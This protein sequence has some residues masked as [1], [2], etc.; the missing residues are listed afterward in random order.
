MEHKVAALLEERR[1]LHG[2]VRGILHHVSTKGRTNRP[3]GV[4]SAL[5]RLNEVT[6]RVGFVLLAYGT[7]RIGHPASR[8]EHHERPDRGR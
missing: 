1:I 7:W 4:R 3:D 8:R 5:L 2:K 6:F